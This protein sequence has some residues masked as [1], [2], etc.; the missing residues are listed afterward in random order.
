MTVGVPFK[1]LGSPEEIA[2]MVVFVASDKASFST[3][4]TFSADGGKAA[5]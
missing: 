5:L 2:Q 4:A 3:G 1:R